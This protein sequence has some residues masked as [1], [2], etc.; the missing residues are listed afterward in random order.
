MKINV[1][2]GGKTV[3]DGD[4]PRVEG[5]NPSVMDAADLAKR[6]HRI[7]NDV[8]R[9]EITEYWL[10]GEL[11]HRSVNMELKTGIFADAIQADF[12]EPNN[13]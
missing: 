6:E 10:H 11:V 12:G 7:D 4:V 13:G 9:T 5:G 1:I 8:E 3:Y 2:L